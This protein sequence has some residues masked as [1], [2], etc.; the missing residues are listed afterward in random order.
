MLSGFVFFSHQLGS[1]VGAY[2]G[3]YIFD[4]MGSYQWVWW[5]AIALGV[6]A[7][8]IN[9][10]IKEVAITRKAIQPA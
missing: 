10:P 4:Q 8:C 3:G 5:I 7:A 6:F 2:L 9:L 1:F